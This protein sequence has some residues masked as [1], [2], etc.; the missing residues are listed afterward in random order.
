MKTHSHHNL[1]STPTHPFFLPRHL[2]GTH[3]RAALLPEDSS[4]QDLK[5]LRVRL[6]KTG[7]DS[8]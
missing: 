1:P 8:P 5:F 7:K 6:V 3:R 4:A 2:R